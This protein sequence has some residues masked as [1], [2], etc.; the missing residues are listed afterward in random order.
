MGAE[1]WRHRD[2]G[3]KDHACPRTTFPST[4]LHPCPLVVDLVNIVSNISAPVMLP[5]CCTLGSSWLMQEL[6]FI[7]LEMT[8]ARNHSLSNPVVSFAKMFCLDICSETNHRLLT[9]YWL[10]HS[11]PSFFS[12]SLLLPLSLSFLFVLLSSA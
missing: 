9:T 4:V 3:R 12:G 6:H 5:T 2:E 7:S 1:V 10:H 11:L 8:P